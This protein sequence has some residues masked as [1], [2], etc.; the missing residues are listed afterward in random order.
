MTYRFSIVYWDPDEEKEFD[1][2]GIVFAE[3]YSEAVKNLTDYC[4]EEELFSLTLKCL[5]D[6]PILR[7]TDSTLDKI[8][9]L[10]L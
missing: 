1:D 2:T 9:E 3:T 4:G 7:A 5:D 10:I 8:E 6:S